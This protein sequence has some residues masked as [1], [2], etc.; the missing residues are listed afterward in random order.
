MH[1][2]IDMC[3]GIAGDML[4]A[5]LVDAGATV[6]AVTSGLDALGFG[7]VSLTVSTVERSSLRCQQLRVDVPQEAGWQ[8]LAQPRPPAAPALAGSLHGIRPLPQAHSHRP[9]AAIRDRLAAVALAPRVRERAQAVFRVLAEAEGAVH[10]VAPERVEFH[11]VGARDAIVDV[12]GCALAL[13]HLGVDSLTHGDFLLGDGRVRCAH[14]EMPVPVPAVVEMLKGRP[15]NARAAPAGCGELTTPTGCA[16]VLGLG[17]RPGVAPAGRLIAVGHGA[18]TRNVPGVAG[19]VRVLLLETAATSPPI[20][21]TVIEL[22]SVLDDQTGEDLAALCQ[23]L[24]T[25]GARDAW[26][27]PLL[28]KKG[29]PGHELVALAAPADEARLADLILEHSGSLGLRRSVQQRRLLPRH[30]E[31]VHL[32]GLELHRKVT[33]TPAGNRRCKAES[34]DVERLAQHGA[35]TRAEARQRIEGAPASQPTDTPTTQGIRSPIVTERR[36][37]GLSS[38]TTHGSNE[39]HQ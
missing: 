28:M 34:D 10:G 26:L 16:L 14:G 3:G 7:P 23:R 35:R 27:V 22:R 18:G 5:A 31:T 21:D 4:L 37:G 15:L 2:H 1:L 36:A 11:E 25:A 17:A 13:E 19:F 9:Y 12:V 39:Y 20:S 29:R 30:C 32:D 24:L 8:P 6:A 33:I 38:M